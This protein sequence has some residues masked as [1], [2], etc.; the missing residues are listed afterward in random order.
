MDISRTDLSLLASL[1]VLLEEA[2]VSRAAARLGI[3][4]PALSSQLA[5]LR[6]LFGDPLLVHS[7]RRMLPTERA[8]ALRSPLSRIMSDLDLL[9]RQQSTF[10]ATTAHKT[11]RIS[12]PDYVHA[13]FTA[14]AVE[15]VMI[16]APLLRLAMVAADP[17]RSWSDMEQDRID[18]LMTSRQLTPENAIAVKL[19]E[20]RFVMAQ[21]KRHPRG[22]SNPDLESFCA[23][24]HILVSTTG[25][26][27]SGPVDEA[28]KKIGQSRRV[29]VSLPSF[30]LAP[31]VLQRSD[32][33][34]VLPESLADANAR[35]L[36]V[37]PLPFVMPN[38]SIVLSWHPKCQS[39]PAQ[40]WLKTK[41]LQAVSA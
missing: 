8:A 3:S 11:F 40:M 6:D 37:F 19:K 18:F 7:G 41:V 26:S 29:S 16:A 31:R 38:F 22:R 12:A 14:P 21:R 28:L 27:F 5:R 33:V 9:V 23:L 20:E 24:S 36:D 34:A 32:H 13:V 30:L 25:G 15:K 1:Q 17:A 35:D 10:D 4:Q 2:N 39:D